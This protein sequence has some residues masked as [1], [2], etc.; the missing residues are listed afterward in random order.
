MKKIIFSLFIALGSVTAVQAATGDADAGKT[1]ASTCSACHGAAGISASPMF[2]NLAGQND[3][4]IIKQLQNFKSGE[5]ADAMMAPMAANLSEQ[6]MADLAA[7]FSALPRVAVL[8]A[9]SDASSA[10][11]STAV[12]TGSVEI[13]SSTP[14]AA[15]YAGD[16]GAGKG[17]SNGLCILSRLRR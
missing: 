17:Q 10:T 12:A 15:I 3:V 13:I 9:S 5:R 2:P 11:A 14:A 16:V 1:K 7:H 8:A 6:D 4:Y